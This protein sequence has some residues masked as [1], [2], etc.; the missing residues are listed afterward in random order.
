MVSV[1]MRLATMIAW[2]IGLLG[3]MPSFAQETAPED[4]P[5]EFSR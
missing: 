2:L 3:A 5:L 1:S 4:R